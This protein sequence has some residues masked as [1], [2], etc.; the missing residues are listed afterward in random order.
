[1]QSRKLNFMIGIFVL[2]MGV[3]A[4][5]A[6]KLLN[7]RI[8][9]VGLSAPFQGDFRSI[10]VPAPELPATLPD[11]TGPFVERRDN[12]IIVKTKSLEVGGVVANSPT[13][14][15]D[16]SGPQVEV[17]ITS[18]TV[19][20]RD[21]TQPGEPFSAENQTV[22]Q[23]VE[24]AALDDLDSQLMVMV[25]GRKRGDRIIA[26]VLMYSDITAIKSAIFKDCE[27]CP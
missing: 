24:K 18:K 23:T 6:G 10:I 5:M 22:Q 20:Y 17:L 25:W 13:N 16:Q 21:T 11:V 12:T 26:D 15:R 9:P 8:E 7:Q 2:L 27:I 14:T 1:M 4:F 19:I 3:A